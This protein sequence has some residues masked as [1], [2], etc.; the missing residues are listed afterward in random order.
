MVARAERHKYTL[1]NRMSE[2]RLN[3]KELRWLERHTTLPPGEFVSTF[4]R[5]RARSR[6][7][8]QPRRAWQPTLLQL[9]TNINDGIRIQN[10]KGEWIDVPSHFDP[11][12]EAKL[13]AVESGDFPAFCIAARDL[14]RGYSDEQ[15]TAETRQVQNEG[16]KLLKKARERRVSNQKAQRRAQRNKRATVDAAL[17]ENGTKID[18]VIRDLR[19]VSARS[20]ATTRLVNRDRQRHFP[21]LSSILGL[22]DPLDRAAL[23][24]SLAVP[25]QFEMPLRFLQEIGY[26]EWRELVDKAAGGATRDGLL[27][28][29]ESLE[30]VE[31]LPDELEGLDAQLAALGMPARS[32]AISEL[33][34]AWKSGQFL[35]TALI[36]VVT[37][38]G[39]LWDLAE[40]FNRR[41]IRIY[42]VQ[43]KANGKVAQYPY[44]WD[45]T[46]RLYK[47]NG[48]RL[49]L[50]SKLLT[51][52][53]DLL[54]RTRLGS[55]VARELHSFLVEEHADYRNPLLHGRHADS[56]SKYDALLAFLCCVETFREVLRLARADKRGL[57]NR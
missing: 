43:R 56:M 42:K 4:F 12:F 27:A 48:R 53:K 30:G 6:G 21:L 9:L 35:A 57:G 52:G 41:G 29:L 3:R 44:A 38:E 18:E 5:F 13:R 28:A 45:S 34:A 1:D 37:A 22:R 14:V 7:R 47:R 23:G 26:A 24:L 19:S 39:R 54:S 51:S 15:L 46:R 17:T 55:M 36:A 20:L 50:E 40:M 49:M 16:A 8:V 10:N 2:D 31:K 32:S 33:L 11:H 25:A